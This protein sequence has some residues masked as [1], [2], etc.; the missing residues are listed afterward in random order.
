MK[1]KTKNNE[2]VDQQIL[3]N[4]SFYIDCEEIH[5]SGV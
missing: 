3:I 4:L 5:R 2:F 1:K